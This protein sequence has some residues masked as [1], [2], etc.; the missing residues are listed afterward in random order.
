MKYEVDT[1]HYNHN[2]YLHG[3]E[4]DHDMSYFISYIIGDKMIIYIVLFLI[5]SVHCTLYSIRKQHILLHMIC[6][7]NALHHSKTL[8]QKT[9]INNIKLNG[10]IHRTQCLIMIS[11]MITHTHS[12]RHVAVL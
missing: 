1:L 12:H 6:L 9:R 3:H 5:M 2:I 11:E 8:W 10:V 4:R 7:S